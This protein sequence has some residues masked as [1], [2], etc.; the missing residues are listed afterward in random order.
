MI[1]HTAS[2]ARRCRCQTFESVTALP[3]PRKKSGAAPQRKRYY[4]SGNL[5]DVIYGL[6]AIRLAGGG[7]LVIGEEQ[8][9]Q[10]VCGN[11]IIRDQ[12]DKLLPLLRHQGYLLDVSYADE[13]PTNCED[14]N[15]FRDLWFDEALRSQSRID[16][17]C[18]MM[19][20]LIGVGPRFKMAEPWLSVPAREP[21]GKIII[22][23]TFS[24]LPEAWGLKPLGWKDLVNRYGKLM[25][26]VGWE[27]EWTHFCTEFGDVEYLPVKDFLDMASAI[28]AAKAFIGNQSFPCAIASGI[29]Q[30]TLQECDPVRPDAKF[31][32]VT[33]RSSK[34]LN[35]FDD[36][37]RFEAWL[38]P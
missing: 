27:H 6:Y 25:L 10:R 13:Y 32:P 1:A 3:F 26:F 22:N 36:P 34:F 33:F 8:R 29:G 37:K 2:L 5:G 11:P 9:T 16:N 18:E 30:R 20:H 21:S 38:A 12:F 15:H 28:K 17:I 4:F 7:S 35:Q 14:M 23:R 24:Y 31:G 19:C